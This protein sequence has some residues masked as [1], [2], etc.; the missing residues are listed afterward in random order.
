MSYMLGEIHEQPEWVERA[1]Q[2]ERGNAA[3][4]VAAMRERDVRFVIIA[5]RGTSDNAAVYAKYLFEI[6]A[7][8]PVALA[9]PSVYTLYDAKIRLDNTLVIGIS[10]SGQGT[11]VVQALSYAR[12]SGALTA[13]ITNSADSPITDVSDHVLLCHAG[14]EKAVA[15]TKTYTTALAVVAL[16]VGMFAENDEL[17]KGLEAIP[18]Q[19]TEVLT[20][21]KKVEQSVERYRYMQECAVLARGINQ[22]TALE[23]ALKMTETS[24]VVAKPYSGADF[25]HGPIAMV[26]FGFPCFLY[27]PAGRVY[28]FMLEL[29]LKIREREGEMLIVAYEKEILELAT[30]AIRMPVEVD[31]LLSPLTCILPGQLFAYYLAK[32]KGG[33]PD[34]PRGLTK[35]TL[36]R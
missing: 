26:D 13:C 32:A 36:T 20:V 18:Q 7:G 33:D 5:A 21:A 2:S 25:L 19:M 3:R 11:D 12:G 9:A 24:Y 34:S 28:P 31:E 14:P 16:L 22:S 35:V 27:A 1:T 29:A 30:T 6:V 15:A 17:L 10:Q 4:L 8:L 23:C